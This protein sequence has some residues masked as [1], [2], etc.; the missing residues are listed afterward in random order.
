LLLSLEAADVSLVRFYSACFKP[1]GSDTE[2]VSG[3]VRVV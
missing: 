1:A 3:V 2:N